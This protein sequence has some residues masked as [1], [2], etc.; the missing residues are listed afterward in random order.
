MSMMN[1]H[2]ARNTR[3][4]SSPPVNV[5]DTVRSST[6]PTVGNEVSIE[7]AIS[8]NDSGAN[9]RPSKKRKQKTRKTRGKNK[10]KFALEGPEKLQF[11]A[12]GQPVGPSKKVAEFGRFIGQLASECSNFPLNAENW[13]EICKAGK[14]DEAWQTVQDALDW[15]DP[16]TLNLVADIKNVVVDKLHERW[17][18]FKYKMKKKWYKPFMGMERRFICGNKHVHVGQWRALVSTW[19]ET[20]NQ[21]VAETNVT[22]RQQLKLHQTTG[23]KTYAQMRYQWECEHPGEVL[24]RVTF[25]GIVYGSRQKDPSKPQ[26]NNEEA[27]K[28]FDEFEEL[29]NNV[30]IEGRE[31][32]HEVRNELFHKV[33]GPEKRNRVRGYGIGAKWADVPGIVTQKN[34]IKYQLLTLT[35]AYEAERAANVRREANLAQ[36]LK[37][38]AE[39][40]EALQASYA[41]LNKKLDLMQEQMGANSLTQIFAAGGINSMESLDLGLLM[42]FL[43]K[44]DNP[45]AIST[46]NVPMGHNIGQSCMT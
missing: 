12:I 45:L 11:N 9:D 38:S 26:P 22:N 10:P 44:P 30:R 41:Q 23:T 32:T 37:E 40:E 2:A 13:A 42:N 36:Q 39:R 34:G 43:K 8:V 25:F 21:E 7:P 19:D 6:I 24:D 35:E 17:R 3:L 29:E 1:I 28:K 14:V 20:K 5:N 15:S 16:E 4:E 33:M 46:S 18:S 27:Q 31:V